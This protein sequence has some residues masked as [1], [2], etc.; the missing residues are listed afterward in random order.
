MAE[1]E[2]AQHVF[3]F[4]STLD[5]A[6]HAMD[7]AVSDFF[8]ALSFDIEWI[9]KEFTYGDEL[10]DK[11]IEKKKKQDMIFALITALLLTLSALTGTAALFATPLTAGV[12]SAVAGAT[13]GAATA[14]MAK[15][16]STASRVSK[17]VKVGIKETKL[18]YR[19]KEG[20]QVAEK[21]GKQVENL[22]T[23][24]GSIVTGKK[25]HDVLAK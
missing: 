14:M 19:G 2:L 15:V 5:H 6:H 23:V 10:Q 8:E 1:K 18:G 3:E 16:G 11:A 22:N 12:S 25:Y 21:W 20:E 9:P 24:A 17:F 7:L 4:F 13:A